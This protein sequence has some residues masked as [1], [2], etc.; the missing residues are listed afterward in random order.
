MKIFILFLSVVSI[1]IANAQSSPGT[2]IPGTTTVREAKDK[3]KAQ[4]KE[5]KALL[6]CIRAQT[7]TK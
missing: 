6:E 3:C 1:S 7:E 5:G 2:T 4:G